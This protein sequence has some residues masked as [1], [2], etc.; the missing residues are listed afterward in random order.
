MLLQVGLLQ[1]PLAT[2]AEQAAKVLSAKRPPAGVAECT[3]PEC[4]L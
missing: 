1:S 3:L 4:S 2:G